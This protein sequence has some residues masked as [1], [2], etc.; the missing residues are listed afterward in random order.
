M[1]WEERQQ[2]H[3]LSKVAERNFINFHEEYVTTVH[4]LEV[5]ATNADEAKKVYVMAVA[6]S[7]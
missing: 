3:E 4:E 6:K 7:F 5:E 1:L 2:F